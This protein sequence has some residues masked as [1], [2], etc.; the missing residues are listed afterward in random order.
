MLVVD[1]WDGQKSNSNDTALA[2]HGHFTESS[3]VCGVLTVLHLRKRCAYFDG[4]NKTSFQNVFLVPFG[5]PVI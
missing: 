4:C 3:R 5:K 1:S 2:E